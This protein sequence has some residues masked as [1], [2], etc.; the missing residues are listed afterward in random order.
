MPFDG[1]DLSQ[2]PNPLSP[3]A[4][5][6]VPA[7]ARVRLW[8]ARVWTTLRVP[9]ALDRSAAARQRHALAACLLREARALVEREENW[10]VKMY[11][12]I[13]GKHCAVGA[14]QS[15]AWGKYGRRVQQQA[16]CRL[17]GVARDRG[18]SHVEKMNDKSSHADVLAAFDTAIASA[19]TSGRAA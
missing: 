1:S 10:A 14:L 13:D 9:T 18:F 4:S 11:Y 12:T 6:W 8:L 3:G 15:A 17:L 19:D 2:S 7:P 5:P 16:H